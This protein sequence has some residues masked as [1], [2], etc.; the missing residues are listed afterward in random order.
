MH[1]VRPHMSWNWQKNDWPHFRWDREMLLE[2]EAQFLYQS[3]VFV[4]ASRHCQEEDKKALTVEII[5]GEAMKTSEIE[6]EYLDR[7]SVQSSIRRHFGID[8]AG[9]RVSPA[10]RGIAEMMT[11][12][13]DTF[14]APLS[15]A[16]LCAWHK[17]LTGG[18]N[19]LKEV[20]RYRAHAEPMRVVSGPIH[21]P[22]IHFEAP[23]SGMVEKEMD[24]FLA[25]FAR[26][27]PGGK[28][29]LPAL[30]RAGIAHLYFVCIHPFED[31]NGRIARAIAEKAL[32]QYLGHPALIALSH[33]IDHNRNAYYDALARNNRD[34]E[35][36][37]WLLYFAKTALEAW[38]FSLEMLEFLIKKTKLYDRTK[39]M[40]NERQAK[41]ID[42]M[43]REGP[44]GFK[45]GMSA[46]KYAGITG[47][48]SA[49]VTRDLHD[50]VEKGVLIRTGELR[51]TRYYLNL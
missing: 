15:H 43:L 10:E 47:A 14:D 9:R 41:A 8:V 42:R 45:G 17:M 30:T 7:D 34:N 21:N 39:G 19:D 12:I 36:T 13:Y 40:L 26:T 33:A 3:G 44:A 25:W 38:A 32:S 22:K 24:H 50:L 16:M 1:L 48:P 29:S 31:G 46:G 20:G 28:E 18:R 6:G 37:T 5:T 27:A 11:D 51:G 35:I 4:G 49:T 23:P 2:P